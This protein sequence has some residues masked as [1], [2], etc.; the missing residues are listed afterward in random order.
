MSDHKAEI[1]P[2]PNGGTFRKKPVEIEARRLTDV[3]AGEIAQWCFGTVRGGP[4]GGSRG[5]SVL[6]NTLE[7]RMVANVGDWI[8]EG[9]RGE[10]YPCRED[11]FE[12]T[13]ERV[14]RPG[15]EG[16]AS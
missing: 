12:E 4:K 15:H 2:S 3:N 7:G 5:G 14:T 10:F 1:V 13:Y 11:I 9:V 8:I 16:G 6:I